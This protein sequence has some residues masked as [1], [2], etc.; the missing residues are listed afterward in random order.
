[1]KEANPSYIAGTSMGVMNMF[2]Y[3]IGIHLPIVDSFRLIQAIR[4]QSHI[5]L[6]LLIMASMVLIAYLLTWLM[7]DRPLNQNKA[8]YDTN[9]KYCYFLLVYPRH[10]DLLWI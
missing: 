6:L 5:H 9:E 7:S 3:D 2:K 8:C 4:C 10:R 1:M